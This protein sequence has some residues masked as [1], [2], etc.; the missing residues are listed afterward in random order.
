MYCTKEKKRYRE[1]IQGGVWGTKNVLKTSEEVGDSEGKWR[2]KDR[3][4]ENERRREGHMGRGNERR[5]REKGRG[6]RDI[7]RKEGGWGHGEKGIKGGERV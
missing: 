1:Q 4:R 2:R 6:R 7:G 5:E 3:K